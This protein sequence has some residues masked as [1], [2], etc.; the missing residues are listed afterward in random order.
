MHMDFAVPYQDRM[1]LVAFDAHSKWPEVTTMKSTTTG[2]TIEAL[3]LFSRFGSPTQLVS[4]NGPQL[5]SHAFL[6]AN[7]VQHIT[8]VPYHPATKGL[9]ERF[10]HTMKH[11]LKTS[12]HQGTLHQRLH[13]YLFNYRNSPHATTMT[14]PANLMFKRDL[15]TT[16]D[17]LKPSAVKETVQKTTRETNYV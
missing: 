8:S 10:V 17:L 2:K 4:D 1:F 13:K 12:L 9:A 7:G 11:A 5:V 15:H 14:S 16:F 6:H 3:E